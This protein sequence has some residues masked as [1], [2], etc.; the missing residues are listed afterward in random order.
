MSKDEEIKLIEL[1]MQMLREI[2]HVARI[3]N[4]YKLIRDT[5]DDLQILGTLRWE[6]KKC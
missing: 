1:Q 3:L 4:N 2:N 6:L 5:E